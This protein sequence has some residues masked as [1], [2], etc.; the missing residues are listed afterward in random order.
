M[1]P[2]RR[3]LPPIA[4]VTA[5]SLLISS[6]CLGNDFRNASLALNEWDHGWVAAI[7]PGEPLEIDLAGNAVYPEAPWQVAEFNPAVVE[8]DAEDHLTPRPPSGDPEG[9]EAE[10]YDPGSLTSRSVY[11]FVGV[12]PGET[13]LRFEIVVDGEPIDVAEYTVVVVEDSCEAAT[14]AVANRCGG[15]GF[16]YDPQ[17]GSEWDYGSPLMLEP[18][19]EAEFTLTANALYPDTPWQIVDFDPAVVA[20]EGHYLGAA[21]QP[22][23]LSDVDPE[24]SHSFLP[25]WR[26]SVR[27]IALGESP[28]LIEVAVDGKRVDV[29]ERPVIVIADPDEHGGP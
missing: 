23:D 3:K 11:T 15:D 21:R 4:L 19:G 18:G 14:A 26:F 27:G 1:N 17:T 13:P 6:G 12:A 2:C 9:M 29:Y 16:R 7:E 5:L 28:L 24:N 22:G 25:A 20:V 10:D 8:L